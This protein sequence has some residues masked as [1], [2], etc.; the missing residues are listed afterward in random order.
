MTLSRFEVNEN[1]KKLFTSYISNQNDF[2][3]KKNERSGKEKKATSA[4][5]EHLKKVFNMAKSKFLYNSG[6][7]G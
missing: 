3:T 5:H 2:Y 7:K 1:P 4:H 6:G